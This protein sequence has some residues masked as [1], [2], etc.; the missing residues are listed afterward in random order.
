MPFFL[1][2]PLVG[3]SSFFLSNTP[4]VALQVH[5]FLFALVLY[6]SERI[7]HEVPTKI[8]DGV[9]VWS[10]LD[11]VGTPAV[12]KIDINSFNLMYID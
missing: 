5:F 9:N 11:A 8:G 6:N 7:E 1:G 4:H 12:S 10:F 2:G 3:I